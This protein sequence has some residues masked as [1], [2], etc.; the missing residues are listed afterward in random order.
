MNNDFNWKAG[1]AIEKLRAAW[2]AGTATEAIALS[3]GLTK[4]AVIGKAHRLRLTPRPS[5]IIARPYGPPPPPV[6]RLPRP[7]ATHLTL[8]QSAPEPAPLPVVALIRE[9]PNCCWPLWKGAAPRHNP[10]YCD[11]PTEGK[12]RYCPKHTMSSRPAQR[13]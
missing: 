10:P 4:N 9:K 3:M 6:I 1:G 13:P 7:K 2:D 11:Q 8:V 12:A 5:P